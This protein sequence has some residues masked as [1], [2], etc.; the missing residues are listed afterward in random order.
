MVFALDL[1]GVLHRDVT[2]G[3]REARAE[4]LAALFLGAL[5]VVAFHLIFG[6]HAH[7]T[8]KRTYNTHRKKYGRGVVNLQ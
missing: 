1:V 8:H 6:T 5:S 4:S 3:A 2:V 7:T